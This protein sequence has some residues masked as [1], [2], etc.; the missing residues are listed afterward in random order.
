MADKIL[1]TL[2]DFITPSSWRDFMSYMW[3]ELNL[4]RNIY[5]LYLVIIGNYVYESNLWK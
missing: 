4:E 1:R 5:F 2:S 3:V